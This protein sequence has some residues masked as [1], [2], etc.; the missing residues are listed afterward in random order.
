M[1]FS[2]QKIKQGGLTLED[3][4]RYLDP[5]EEAIFESELSDYEWH[6]VLDSDNKIIAVFQIINVLNIY[7]KNLTIHFHPTFKQND[8]NIVG[9]IMFIYESMLLICDKK[10]IKTL[11]L[12]ID[13]S[14]IHA[15]FMKIAEHQAKNK[16]IIDMK[17]YGKWIEIQMK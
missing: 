15:V 7:S 3:W 5:T 6:A 1:T 16:D 2:C 14:L 9:I 8:Y 17:N 11:K 13:D 10:D 4:K 12:Y